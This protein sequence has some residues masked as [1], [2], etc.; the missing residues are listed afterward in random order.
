M[1]E[2]PTRSTSRELAMR[3]ALAKA[4][5]RCT[6]PG[7]RG[8]RSDQVA[9]LAGQPL[10]KASNHAVPWPVAADAPGRPWWFQTAVAELCQATGF[11]NRTRPA[12][13]RAVRDS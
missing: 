3:L 1:D 2:K 5:G 12:V 11:A 6:P 10:G 9:D 4:G 7:C 8:H 13:R